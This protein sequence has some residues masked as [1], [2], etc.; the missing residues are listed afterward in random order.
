MAA[1]ATFGIDITASDKTAKGKK[2]AE[3]TLGQ[4]QKNL[5]AGNK[6]A[7]E[8][9]ER[10]IGGS[11]RRMVRTF[12]AVEKAASKALGGKSITGG[13]A[14]RMGG[15]GKAASVLGS[16]LG[17]ASLA[18]GALGGTLGVVGIAAAGT[19][20]VL[21]AAAY[22]AFKLADGWAKGAASIGRTAEI[23]GVGTKA[24]QEFT[25]AAERAGVSRDT[26]AGAVGGLSQTLNDARYGRNN[27]A[28]ALLSKMGVALKTKSDGTVDVEAMMPQIA[29]ALARQNSSGRRTA[30]RILG[31]PQGAL[32]AFTQGGKALSADMADAGVHGPVISDEGISKAKRFARG[33]VMGAQM[34]EKH[35]NWGKEKIVDGMIAA[36]QSTVGEAVIK[37]ARSLDSSSRTNERAADKTDRAASTMER[38]ATV[39]SGSS[40]RGHIAL[41]RDVVAAAQA[42]EKKYGIPASVTLAQFGLESS[43]GR[44][45][46]PGSNNPFG[47]KAKAGEP[48][49]AS[50]TREEDR[51][52]NSYW[53][54]A[55]FRKFDS[56]AEAFDAHARLLATARPYA[57]ARRKLPDTDAFADAL[58]GTYATDHLYGSKLRGIIHG[59]GFDRFDSGNQA[60]PPIPVHVTVEHKNAPPGTRTTVKAGSGPRPA[61]S[62]A[63]EQGIVPVHGG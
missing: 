14:D 6:K 13:L 54:N 57:A 16:S 41:A 30:A 11:G 56:L 20:G 8:E 24:F 50:R 55:R 4:I 7:A 51:N 1:Q 43:Y 37:T 53:V 60:Q 19:I 31:I 5:S 32:P 59:Q 36:A 34:I 18:G 44:R 49:V 2:S 26:A 46:P 33:S 58:T 9:T 61:V 23:I 21:A 15:I 47:I 63:F 62:H 29:D 52:G 35:T 17:E 22:G 48:F 38:A 39:I 3:K 27:D 12:G 10:T 25:L 42:S 40:G 45:M 28:V